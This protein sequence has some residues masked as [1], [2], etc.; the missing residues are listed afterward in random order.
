MRSKS[1]KNLKI[2]IFNLDVGFLVFRVLF[3]FKIFIGKNQ[4]KNL[5]LLLEIFLLNL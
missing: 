2:L 3:N 1:N 4:I 5:I